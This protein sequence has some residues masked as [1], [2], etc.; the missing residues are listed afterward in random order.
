MTLIEQL[1]T[2][3]DPRGAHGKRH[4]LWQVLFVSLWGSLCGYWGYRPLAQFCQKHHRTLCQL[5]GLDPDKTMLPSYSTFRRVFQLVDAQAW[6]NAF[7]VWAILHAPELAGLVWSIDGKSIKCT[8][9]GGNSAAQNFACLVSVYGKSVGVV[10][11]ELMYNA[12]ASEIAVARRLV[13]RITQAPSLAQ[14]LPLTFSLD[15]LHAQV[16]TLA[17]LSTRQCRYF[18]GL[19]ANQK[20][21]FEQMQSLLTQST[22]L[23]EATHSETLHGRHTQRTAKVYAV[24]AHLPARWAKAAI[25]RVIWLWRRGIRKG[26][27]FEEHHC[28]LS[29]DTLDAMTF[30]EVARTHWQIENGL[31]WVKDVTLEEDDPPRRG[32]FAPINWAVFNSFLITLARRLNCRTLPDAQRELANQVQQVFLWLT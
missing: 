5:L 27:P 8:A 22:P 15:A 30:L 16:D 18:I 17:L 29:N 2:I 25:Q 7:N 14:S 32:G 19:K 10:Q 12:K 28:Y 13:E 4:P 1:K 9:T 21:L 24:P 20:K 3:P 26:K 11:L 31:H 23:S 6:V